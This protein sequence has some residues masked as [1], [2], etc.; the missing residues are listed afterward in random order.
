MRRW[1][2]GMQFGQ[3]KRREFITLLGAAAVAWPVAARAQQTGRVP[4]IGVLMALAE[5]DAELKLWLA[6]FREKIEALGWTDGRNVH[7]DY[8]FAPAA[9]AAKAQAFVKELMALQPDVIFAQSTP[10]VAALRAETRNIP[11]VFV[12]VS[13]PIGSGFIASFARPGGNLTGMGYM[14][15]GM[16]C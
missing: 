12:L 7:I 13:D 15:A 11:I 5:D 16:P 4:R 10:V 14:E 6:G 2:H 9:N 1:Q 8:R 3:L